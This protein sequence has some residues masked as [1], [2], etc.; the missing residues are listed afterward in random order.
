M[1]AGGTGVRVPSTDG[2][3]RPDRL[4]RAARASPCDSR[5]R[6]FLGY[7][8]PTPESP[9][10]DHAIS[11]P[12]ERTSTRGEATSGCDTK[13]ELNYQAQNIYLVMWHWH[14]DNLGR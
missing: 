7:A 1:I 3:R 4:E 12:F 11:W 8:E 5:S 9:G 2:A 13:L 14:L 10:C 6:H